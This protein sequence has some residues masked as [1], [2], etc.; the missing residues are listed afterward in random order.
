MDIL[1]G[2]TQP[3]TEGRHPELN[4]HDEEGQ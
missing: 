3:A 1:L 2:N 4:H